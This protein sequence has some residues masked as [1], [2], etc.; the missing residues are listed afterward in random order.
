M[1]LRQRWNLPRG[2]KLG[3]TRTQTPPANWR[4]FEVGCYL[5]ELTKPHIVMTTR[6]SVALDQ[7]CWGCWGCSI[8][9]SGVALWVNAHHSSAG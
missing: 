5:G 2:L 3:A 1:T 6:Y 4:R 9:S 7:G 8:I